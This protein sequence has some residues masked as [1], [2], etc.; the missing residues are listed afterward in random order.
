MLTIY[1]L[2]SL[3]LDVDKLHLSYFVRPLM[4]WRI[5]KTV[6]LCVGTFFFR[7]YRLSSPSTLVFSR[8]WGRPCCH[9]C[10]THRLPPAT[11]AFPGR[12]RHAPWLPRHFEGFLSLSRGWRESWILFTRTTLQPLDK[13]RRPGPKS[14]WNGTHVSYCMRFDLT[15]ASAVRYIIRLFYGC[16][17]KFLFP[18]CQT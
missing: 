3:V 16:F 8:A 5:P 7:K 13:G 14:I 6:T 11:T 1:L 2:L 4:K 12:R 9:R 17:S 10:P 15:L 18:N